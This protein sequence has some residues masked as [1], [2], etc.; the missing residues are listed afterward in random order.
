MFENHEYALG[1]IILPN[2]GDADGDG[3]IDCWDG[4]GLTG[5]W[6]QY[7]PDSSAKFT[8]IILDVPSNIDG[9]ALR[10]NFTY[11]WSVPTWKDPPASSKKPEGDN[12]IRVWEKDGHQARLLS[13]FM[14][15]NHYYTLSELGWQNGQNTLTLYVEGLCETS[16][17]TPALARS[18]G[19]PDSKIKVQY[20]FP[21]AFNS[22]NL[23]DEVRAVVAGP[24]SFYYELMN[25]PE[26]HALYAAC[27]IYERENKK[28]YCLEIQ[29]A[30]QL[31]GLDLPPQVCEWLESGT[32][33]GLDV[34]LYREY[35]KG[36]YI[37]AFAGTT[38]P[39]GEHHW[40]DAI[41]DVRQAFGASVAQYQYAKE[42]GDRFF[43]CNKLNGGQ[44]FITGHSLGGGLA[45]TASI[46][47]GFRCYTFNSAGVHPD[48]ID[49]PDN[50]DTFVTNYKVDWDILSWGQGSVD[51]LRFIF[52]DNVPNSCGETIW[53]RSTKDIE[54]GIAT[55]MRL[56]GFI[57]SA[58]SGVTGQPYGVAIGAV[59]SLAGHAI[60]LQ[61]GLE[62]HYRPQ[63]IYG[64]EK[65]I[66]GTA[67]LIE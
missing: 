22:E 41:D 47:S 40:Q 18:Q 64:M 30:E 45:C 36:K 25:H 60:A 52:G 53:I 15:T 37:L 10:L 66:F 13:D 42:I 17:S 57:V 35:I 8:P 58:L 12:L 9:E 6:D 3:R 11:N 2:H 54:M 23:V 16:V 26:L 46:K 27:A 31:Q 19:K 20:G 59:T 4:Y 39:E 29:S 14:A 50:A 63:C 43:G 24:G 28:E 51:W 33:D 32:H 21:D 67:V 62:C 1:K 55:G 56:G 65:R 5:H 38:F 34:G 7:N 44:C 48:T 61:I 49:I